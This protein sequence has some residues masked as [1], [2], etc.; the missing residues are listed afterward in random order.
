[1]TGVVLA[2]GAGRRFGR[3][4]ALVEFYG[5]RLVDRAVDLLRAGGCDRVVVVS[6]AARLEVPRAEVVHNPDWRSGMGSSLCAGLTAVGD[7]DAV[8]IP[9]DMPWLGPGSVRRIVSSGASLAVATYGGT[10]AHPVLLGASHRPGII[11][12]AVGDIGARHYLRDHSRLVLEVPCDGTG[13]PRDIDHPGDLDS[14]GPPP[15]GG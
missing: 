11:A 6:G 14:A 7:E 3:P 2:A 9:V 12:S 5:A 15:G 13:S 10:R 4:K 1:M 8:V